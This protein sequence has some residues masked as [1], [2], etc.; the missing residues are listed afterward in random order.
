M[1]A[2]D[3]IDSINKSL[4]YYDSHK[5]WRRGF[6]EQADI[7]KLRNLLLKIRNGKE[8]VDAADF[9]SLVYLLVNKATKPKHASNAA[10]SILIDELRLFDLVNAVQ[11]LQKHH[12][13]LS[14][15]ELINLY[16][17][18]S[19]LSLF[20]WH[21]IDITQP[22]VMSLLF[23]N[24]QQ[25][26]LCGDILNILANDRNLSPEVCTILVNNMEML[27]EIKKTFNIVQDKKLL[28]L[29]G[30]RNEINLLKS[31]INN[32]PFIAKTDLAG[33]ITTLEELISH[34]RF[35]GYKDLVLARTLTLCINGKLDPANLDNLGNF[36][37]A[38]AIFGKDQSRDPKLLKL[39]LEH[40][41]YALDI[42]LAAN[43]CERYNFP[44]SM[45][46]EMFSRYPQHARGYI[47]LLRTLIKKFKISDA[48]LIS[49]ILAGNP[50]A[51][52]FHI[53]AA[54]T[55]IKSI[56]SQS[57]F[58]KIIQLIKINNNVIDG[59]LEFS[60]PTNAELQMLLDHPEDAKA[61]GLGIWRL[62]KIGKRAEFLPDLAINTAQA[63]KVAFA[64]VELFR[65]GLLDKE[66]SLAINNIPCAMTTRAAIQHFA[67]HISQIGP[68]LA[69]L[70]SERMLTIENF[71]LLCEFAS[72]AHQLA[73]DIIKK[74]A[75]VT[76]SAPAMTPEDEALLKEEAANSPSAPALQSEA[77]ED[78]MFENMLT[79][80]GESI[81][82]RPNFEF[83]STTEYVRYVFAKHGRKQNAS[84]DTSHFVSS[85]APVL[86]DQDPHYMDKK[87]NSDTCLQ[88]Y[89]QAVEA[90]KVETSSG[91]LTQLRLF[92][93]HE[94]LQAESERIRVE[95]ME[96]L[97]SNAP[98]L[99]TQ[100][101][102]EESVGSHLHFSQA[103]TI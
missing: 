84:S 98:K 74:H 69:L 24:A 71:K 26:S 14:E 52:L 53:S 59:L 7:I 23:L 91:T 102:Q 63:D 48:G 51:N 21:N 29:P 100:I 34:H 64:I 81:F 95:Q 60:S 5:G 13:V 75:P 39:I 35:N 88:T 45:H 72:D 36:V 62:H 37:K 27:K 87:K 93:Q 10:F 89:T 50:H 85:V 16:A 82:V 22:S 70:N 31:I 19:I 20:E 66:I 41:N 11:R 49:S 92:V 12:I 67:A 101:P 28:R 47:D 38:M 33:L 94:Q 54:L 56:A 40:P 79:G 4:D 18:H 43:D 78:Q 99:P 58:D 65:A 96:L 68:A 15:S 9:H 3:L 2:R 25:L 76:P 61:L 86:L 42:V 77:D 8:E 30:M 90:M 55:R 73:R 103:L 97:L 80:P 83:K 46:L 1:K 32:I 44:V 57:D 17:N 6:K